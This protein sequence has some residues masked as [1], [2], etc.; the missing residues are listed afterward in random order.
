MKNDLI[1]DELERNGIVFESL[2]HELPEEMYRW[3]PEPK[4]WNLLD[5]I[6]HLVD[7][8]RED[9]K[10]RMKSLLDD[11]AKAFKPIKP[12]MWVAE[13]N[14]QAQDFESRLL[15]F[16]EEREATVDWLRSLDLP[17]WNNKREEPKLGTVTAQMLL[18]NLLAHDHLHIRQIVAIKQAY[19]AEGSKAGLTYAGDW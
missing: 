5:V 8:E 18:E 14:Y 7:E 19:L 9:F 11:P 6:C 3:R 10:A 1:I 4:K 13:R 16:C 15:K 12:Q 17:N 2:L